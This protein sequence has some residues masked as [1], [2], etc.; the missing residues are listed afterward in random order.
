MADALHFSSPAVMWLNGGDLLSV[1]SVQTLGTERGPAPCSSGIPRPCGETVNTDGKCCIFLVGIDLV[2]RMLS[3]A[4]THAQ[5]PEFIPLHCI[6]W[7][8]WYMPAGK[9]SLGGKSG[10]SIL[11]FT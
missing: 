5:G 4:S 2:G 11:M 7:V 8:W 9:E 10:E 6:N 1:C 3:L